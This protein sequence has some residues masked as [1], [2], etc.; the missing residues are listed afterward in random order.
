MLE[1]LVRALALMLVFEG[2][3]PFLM[4][5]RLLRIL[6]TMVAIETRH[7]RALGLTC[8]LAGCSI[9]LVMR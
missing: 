9:L 4:P 5:D 6:E 2:I 8:M 3:M 1:D 7:M